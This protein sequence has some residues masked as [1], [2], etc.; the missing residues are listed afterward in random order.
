MAF[1]KKDNSGALFKNEKKHDKSPDYTGEITING[2]ELRLA[3]WLKE[4]ST[5]NKFL[6]LAVTEK[7][8]RQ[9]QQAQPTRQPELAKE[10]DLPF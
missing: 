5:G 7:Q 9:E 8:E 6:S 3:A 4:S 2:K 1:Q 10:D